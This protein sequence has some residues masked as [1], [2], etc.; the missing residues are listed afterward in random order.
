MRARGHAA[1]IKTRWEWTFISE[2]VTFVLRGEDA[3]DLGEALSSQRAFKRLLEW[4]PPHATTRMSGLTLSEMASRV[5]NASHD[6]SFDADLADVGAAVSEGRLLVFTNLCDASRTSPRRAAPPPDE[7]AL[8]GD[9]FGLERFVP[10]RLHGRCEVTQLEVMGYGQRAPDSTRRLLQVVAMPDALTR[11]AL[12]SGSKASKAARQMRDLL[13]LSHRLRDRRALERV[14][15]QAERGGDDGDWE[16]GGEL[17]R[18]TSGAALV[19]V[20]VHNDNPCS[21]HGRIRHVSSLST[22]MIANDLT[23]QR[24]SYAGAQ[25]RSVHDTQVS[26]TR[27]AFEASGCNGKPSRVDV[28][29]FPGDQRTFTVNFKETGDVVSKL[30]TSVNELLRLSGDDG[31]TFEASLEGE[32]EIFEGW[33][34][35]KDWRVENALEVCAGVTLGGELSVA[36]SLI[37]WGFHVPKPLRDLL[38]DVTLTAGVGLSVEVK[39]TVEA[40]RSPVAADLPSTFEASGAIAITVTGSVSLS[41]EARLG[42]DALGASV[43]GK[44]APEITG[45]GEARW[46][47]ESCVGTVSATLA[48][49]DFEVWVCGRAFFWHHDEEWTFSLWQEHE[50]F[51]PRHITL[52]PHAPGGASEAR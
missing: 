9:L 22:R 30:T 50:L 52:Y 3:R 15:G 45:V 36:F 1:T 42:N 5:A 29:V 25:P 39:G 51:A 13:R 37:G 17:V 32:V 46:R 21:R 4:F 2:R 20:G 35:G 43:T 28:E 19:E 38:G 49:C 26:P 11:D 12:T 7:P 14:V 16:A 23:V 48:A 44:V 18:A 40:A 27:Y 31:S 47:D 6:A 8:E 41:I 33:R 10:S 24:L 34:D